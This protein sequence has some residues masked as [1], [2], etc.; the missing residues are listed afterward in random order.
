MS[1]NRLSLKNPIVIAVVVVLG[2]AVTLLNIQTF[3]KGRLPSRRVQAGHQ[4]EPSLP[5]DLISLVRDSGPAAQPITTGIAGSVGRRPDLR[6]DPFLD[7]KYTGAPSVQPVP[8]EEVALVCTAVMLGGKRSAAMIN[9]QAFVVGDRIGQ[10]A[11]ISIETRGVGL[12]G[13][14]GQE[15]YLFV[16]SEDTGTESL[17]MEF[18]SKKTGKQTQTKMTER[19]LP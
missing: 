5:G 19:N 3:G 14:S 9:G 13:A 10:L 8:E 7:Q 6:R 1:A 2:I 16:G 17:K 11:V 18:G 12:R 4:D 15:I